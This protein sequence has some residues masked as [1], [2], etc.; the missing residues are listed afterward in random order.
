MAKNKS[1]VS[2]ENGA[3]VRSSAWL[4]ALVQKWRD[5]AKNTRSRMHDKRFS[6]KRKIKWEAWA[7]AEEVCADDLEM[8][9]AANGPAQ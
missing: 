8:A 5:D 7:R 3:D 6:E 1:K 4:A 9:I 2:A